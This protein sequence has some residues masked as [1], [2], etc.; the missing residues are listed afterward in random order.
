MKIFIVIAYYGVKNKPYLHQ[1]LAAYRAMKFETHVIVLSES[2]KDLGDDVE[3]RVGL[4]ARN[5]WSL[6]FHHKKLFAE[7]QDTY[8]LFI[9]SEDDTLITE[10][11]ITAFLEVSA[12]LPSDRIAGFLRFE[13]N[14]NGRRFY[15]DIHANYHWVLDSV[16]KHGKETFAYFTNEHSAC[17]ILTRAQLKKALASGGFLVP[18]HNGHYDLLCTAATDPYTQCGMKKLICLSRLDDFLIQHLPNTYLGH[19]GLEETELKQQITRLLELTIDEKKKGAFFQL[20]ENGMK[21]WFT[22]AYYPHLNQDLIDRIP[23][24]TK[25]LLS[26]GCGWGKTEAYLVKSGIEV[27]AVPHDLVVMASAQLRGIKTVSP[28]W[29]DARIELAGKQ[30]DAILLEDVLQYWETP[31]EL[32]RSLKPLLAPGGCIL[33]Q[34]INT[35]SLSF[36][37]RIIKNENIM[38][39]LS[40]SYAEIGMHMTHLKLIR[41]WFKC[42]GFPARGVQCFFYKMNSLFRYL[43]KLPLLRQWLSKEIIFR[44]KL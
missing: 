25:T 7:N 19:M 30:F 13:E 17:F 43:G 3:V 28:C 5:P 18:P 9:Y 37:K 32:L 41:K 31:V 23:K 29:Q 39:Q 27:T 8:D 15:P 11:N 14:C 44:I 38:R 22:K 4:P 20:R 24:Q 42:A 21:F 2:K 26:L 10:H 16:E 33:G 6:P 12:C 35:R 34:V 40:L 1:L 36:I